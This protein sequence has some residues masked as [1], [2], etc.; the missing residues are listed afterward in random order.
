VGVWNQAASEGTSRAS[1]RGSGA[2][3]DHGVGRGDPG[4]FGGRAVSR[5]LGV[6]LPGPLDSAGITVPLDD[7]GV[8]GDPVGGLP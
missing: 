4:N 7:D 2:L 5:L 3:G 8:L 1:G 6:D